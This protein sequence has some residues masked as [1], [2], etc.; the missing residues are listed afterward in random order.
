MYFF[1]SSFFLVSS[2]SNSC[3]YSPSLPTQGVEQP[4]KIT[5]TATV[6]SDNDGGM[7]PRKGTVFF[8]LHFLQHLPPLILLLLLLLLVVLVLDRHAWEGGLVDVNDSVDS[9]TAPI[10][11]MEVDEEGYIFIFYFFVFYSIFLF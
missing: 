3:Y 5:V 11:T 6:G 8:L 4:L 2:S 10:T 9:G 1:F 7:E